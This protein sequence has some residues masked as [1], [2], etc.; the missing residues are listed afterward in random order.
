MTDTEYIF[1]A[2]SQEIS[3]INQSEWIPKIS[4]SRFQQIREMTNSD[5]VLQT[6]KTV[7]LTGWN[8]RQEDVP[9]AVRD[10]WNIRDE[11][12][13]QD[14]LIYKSNRVVI[15]K[16]LRPE[17]LSR[18]HS[19]HLGTEACL[20]KA[21]DAVLWPNM[22]ADYA[23]SYRNAALATKCRTNN[24][25]SLLSH[26]MYQKYHGQSYELMISSL[27]KTKTI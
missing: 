22:S 7:I 26:M 10:Y 20:R 8:D 4:H 17:M 13:A 11:L 5:P 18:I 3:Q 19:S 16:V 23:T 1:N 24:Q 15:P 25:S 9:V 6:L 12:S 14:G 2:F 21:R 27:T